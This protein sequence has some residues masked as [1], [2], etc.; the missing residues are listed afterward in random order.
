MT[1][2]KMGAAF[3][4]IWIYALLIAMSVFGTVAI[5]SW[6]ANNAHEFWLLVAGTGLAL[7]HLGQIVFGLHLLE[8]LLDWV[9]R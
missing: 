8:P 3:L 7:V 9:N 5:T 6:L 1:Y 4:V 2:L